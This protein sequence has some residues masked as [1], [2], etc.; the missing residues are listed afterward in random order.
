MFLSLSSPFV[1][2]KYTENTRHGS[3]TYKAVPAHSLVTPLF[4]GIYIYRNSI[5]IPRRHLCQST[6]DHHFLH[7]HS[8]KKKS[9]RSATFG[10]CFP[11]ASISGKIRSRSASPPAC[12]ALLGGSPHKRTEFTWDVPHK[13]SYQARLSPQ[14][15]R[16]YSVHPSQTSFTKGSI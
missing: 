9:G 12:R 15:H 14:A 7:S 11:L 8:K 5:P 2:F 4:F 16:S 13:Y 1:L 6:I 3:P 10:N